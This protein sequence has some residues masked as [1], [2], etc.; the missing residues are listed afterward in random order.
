MVVI[1]KRP[2]L[3]WKMLKLVGSWR[4]FV[5][6]GWQQLNKSHSVRQK[7]IGY[8]LI[9]HYIVIG[10]CLYFQFLSFCFTLNEF[11]LFLYY[12]T[13]ILKLSVLVFNYCSDCINA[14][15]FVNAS[16]STAIYQSTSL[17]CVKFCNLFSVHDIWLK[18]M[19]IIHEGGHCITMDVVAHI[20]FKLHN[21]EMVIF[22]FTTLTSFA[23]G[24]NNEHS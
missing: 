22:H 15:S 23:R 18:S 24:T 16:F 14:I 2:C 8:S 9:A 5:T 17:D 19:V 11:L 3:K 21:A 10:T 13:I 6:G 20:R 1:I 4:K 12:H 7:T